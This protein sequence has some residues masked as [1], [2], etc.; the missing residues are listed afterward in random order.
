MTTVTATFF[1]RKFGETMD[2]ALVEP[3]RITQHGRR[4]AVLLSEEM[5]EQLLQGLGVQAFKTQDLPDHLLQTLSKPLSR[6][7]FEAGG[8]Q[9]TKR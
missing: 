7:E 1:Q 9:Q 3:V 6:D 8:I 4:K 2:K 5:Y